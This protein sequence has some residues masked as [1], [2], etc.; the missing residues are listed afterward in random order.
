MRTFLLFTY[1]CNV[2]TCILIRHRNERFNI[3]I[4]CKS[5]FRC[6]N[7]EYFPSSSLIRD[8]NENKFIKTSWPDESRVNNIRAV[9]CAKYHHTPEFFE[10]V[11]FGK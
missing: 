1:R 10:P 4:L 2:R 3:H 11:H 6:V 5:H 9:G 7:F 8:R